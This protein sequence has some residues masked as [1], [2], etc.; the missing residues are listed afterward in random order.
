VTDST[1]IPTLIAVYI[2][3]QP[4]EHEPRLAALV[5][6]REPTPSLWADA[7]LAALAMSLDCETTTFDQRYT[8]QG[9]TWGSVHDALG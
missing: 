8:T 6:S 1:S 2:D 7:W 5:S 9:R 3:T 4:A